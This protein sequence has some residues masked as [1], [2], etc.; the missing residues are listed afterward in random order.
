MG[1]RITGDFI[2][3][4]NIKTRPFVTGQLQN[5][6]RKPKFKNDLNRDQASKGVVIPLLGG[7][8]K[9]SDQGNGNKAGGARPA[10]CEDG[11][12]DSPVDPKSSMHPVT[13]RC[14]PGCS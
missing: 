6:K 7:R 1:N 13:D 3:A 5:Y 4:R 10:S 11:K 12:A 9:S 14:K 2:V 8:K